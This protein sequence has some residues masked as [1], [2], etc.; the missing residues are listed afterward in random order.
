MPARKPS[1]TFDRLKERRAKTA[2]AP[3]RREPERELTPIAEPDFESSVGQ[4]VEQTPDIPQPSIPQATE[5]ATASATSEF[6]EVSAIVPQQPTEISEDGEG[7][8]F[9]TQEPGEFFGD[10]KQSVLPVEAPSEEALAGAEFAWPVVEP[11]TA[12]RFRGQLNQ[13]R[14]SYLTRSSQLRVNFH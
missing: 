5:M 13:S 10:S 7:A 3:V 14:K 12:E 6:A 8:T 1:G 9:Y 2:Q 4:V 11:S